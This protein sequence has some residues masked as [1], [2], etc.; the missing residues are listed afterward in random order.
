MKNN[1]DKEKV[2]FLN[3]MRLKNDKHFERIADIYI[4]LNGFLAKIIM[5][6][7]ITITSS[8]VFYGG[9]MF[10]SLYEFY[11]FCFKRNDYTVNLY[12]LYYK[13]IEK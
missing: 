9:M 4:Q 12:K 11:L 6:T 3:V 2:T 1:I 8:I 13:T 7:I 5:G 10:H